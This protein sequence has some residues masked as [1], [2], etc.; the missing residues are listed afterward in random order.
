[1][2]NYNPPYS[3]YYAPFYPP[4]EQDVNHSHS[5]SAEHHGYHTS[6]VGFQANNLAK[7]EIKE[8]LA[9]V[10]NSECASTPVKSQDKKSASN[11]SDSNIDLTLPEDLVGRAAIIDTQS[12]DQRKVAEAVNFFFDPAIKKSPARD[13]FNH[14]KILNHFIK[15]T[16]LDESK[17]LPERYLA[18]KDKY[19]TTAIPTYDQWERIALHFPPKKMLQSLNLIQSVFTTFHIPRTSRKLPRYLF[20]CSIEISPEKQQLFSH[21]FK[22]KSLIKNKCQMILEMTLTTDGKVNHCFIRKMKS[23]DEY[24]KKNFADSLDDIKEIQYDSNFPCLPDISPEKSESAKPVVLETFLVFQSIYGITI[25][26]H[27]KT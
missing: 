21:E 11:E 1:M 2:G 22:M 16:D 15:K 14:E 8:A 24:L 19:A 25:K 4:S 9:P 13:T 12:V 27:L 3:N 10:I 18:M 20:P 17:Y 5:C 23:N 7:Y 6:D 26:A